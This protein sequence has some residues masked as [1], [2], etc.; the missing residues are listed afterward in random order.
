MKRF[1][2]NLVFID[3]FN[4]ST[5][6]RSLAMSAS[7]I[8][9]SNLPVQEIVGLQVP[10]CT[11]SIACNRSD[12]TLVL[13]PPERTPKGCAGPAQDGSSAL[14]RV[15]QPRRFQRTQGSSHL[16]SPYRLPPLCF[17]SLY[18]SLQRQSLPLPWMSV[19]A[20][21]QA[22]PYLTVP[23]DLN[24]VFIGFSGDGHHRLNLHEVPPLITRA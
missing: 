16:S 18:L 19:I 22:E 23:V 24:L 9:L 8:R 21:S 5:F 10:S 4:H 15:R 12:Q 2:M 14:G 17:P 3:I 13:F 20:W 7:S 11:A 1:Y 6:N